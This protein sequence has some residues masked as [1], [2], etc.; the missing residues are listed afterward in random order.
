MRIA[1]AGTNNDSMYS[2]G[3][4]HALIVAYALARIGMDVT[5]ITNKRPRFVDDLDPLAPGQVKY[6]FT[7]DFRS[8]IPKENFDYVILIP[9]GIFLPEFYEAVFEFARGA[10]ARMALINFE[11]GNW[12]NAV[13][14]APRDLRLWEYW[15]RAV[16]ES[17]LV[18]SS[19]R[20]SDLYAR[21]FY[22]A[23]NPEDLRFEV[24]GPPIN[25][26]AAAGGLNKPKDGSVIAFVRS[27]DAHKG[28]ADL[29][30]LDP[31]ILAGRTLKIVAG[32]PIDSVFA[33]DL[34]ARFIPAG[35]KVEFH[36]AIS[37][38]EKFVLIGKAQ[39]LLFPSRFEGFGYPPV[40]AAYMGTEVACYDLEV[41]EETVGSVAHFAPVGDVAALG[42]AL[43]EA[44]EREPRQETLHAAV[45]SI[46]DIDEVAL[47]LSDILLR[48][49]NAIRATPD[50]RGHACWGPFVLSD[51]DANI[52]SVPAMPALLRSFRKTGENAY[53]LSVLMCAPTRHVTGT[54]EGKVMEAVPVCIKE[55]D[56][57]FGEVIFE[58]SAHLPDWT[59]KDKELTITLRDAHGAVVLQEQIRL[60]QSAQSL[61]ATLS[62]TDLEEEPGQTKL[63]LKASKN[64]DRIS[65]SH[66]QITWV[67]ADVV[68]G[69]VEFI[70]PQTNLHMS[71]PVFYLFADDQIIDVFSGVPPFPGLHAHIPV[72]DHG[73][74]IIEI[75]DLTNE[76]WNCG[77]LRRPG[78]KSAGVVA[79]IT[80][81]QSRRPH[82]GDTIRLASGRIVR[83]E[84]IDYK[85]KVANL[86]FGVEIDPDNEGYPNA[87][88][89]V[90]R[91]TGVSPVHVSA[92]NWSKGFWSGDGTSGS[93]V[94]LLPYEA[95]DAFDPSLPVSL[96]V[97]G[98][99]EIE[100]ERFVDN[101]YGYVAR[102]S[103]PLNVFG[104]EMPEFDL[105]PSTSHV[106]LD[107]PAD[108]SADGWP[109]KPHWS[110]GDKSGRI[111]NLSP[112]ARV[113]RNDALIFQDGSVRG[114]QDIAFDK[115]A[116]YILLDLAPAADH[117]RPARLASFREKS[118]L[119]HGQSVYPSPV[120]NPGANKVLRMSDNF[121]KSRIALPQVPAKDRPRVL[122]ASIVPPDPANQGNRIVT[123]NFITHLISQGF[124]V[125]LL[126][127]GHVLPERMFHQFGDRVRVFP[128]PF[129]NWT[130]EPS[131]RL[132]R[133]V[134]EELRQ[135]NRSPA[136]S[137]IFD[138]LLE[139]ASH[140]HP[141]YI[142]PDSVVRTARAL[143]RSNE[144]HSI[145]CNY[146]HMIRIACELAPIRPLPP[147]TI[148]THDALSRLPLKFD[149]KPFD[150]M[151][152]RCTPDM[153][154]D[155]LNAVPG[156]T[157][158]AIST[159][160]Q[161][162]FKEIGVTNP[163]E[164][165]EYD[166]LKE[167]ALY[168]V[169]PTAFD[170]RRLI[171]HA[172]NNPMNQ[173]A[174]D[175]FLNNCWSK[176]QRVV[177][178]AKLVI[179]GAI[180]Q[181]VDASIPGIE[182][183]G[184]VER[185]TLMGL[186][187]TSSVAINPTL[188]GTGLKI[189]TVEAICAGLPS[190]CLP[191]AIE[192]LEAVADDFCILA[193]DAPSFVDACVRL[194]TE[195]DTW[196]GLNQSSMALAQKRFSE[197]AIYGAVDARMGWD[198]GTDERFAAARS[199]YSFSEA[200]SLDD[201]VNS[202][203]ETDRSNITTARHLQSI[204][205]VKWA[206]H[207]LNRAS[208]QLECNGPF[209]LWLKSA[210]TANL[211]T[212]PSIALNSTARCLA[213][214]PTEGAAYAE[215]IKAALAQNEMELAENIWQ[216]MALTMPGSPASA[217][218]AED[219]GLLRGTSISAGWKPSPL[220]IPL[221]SKR[222]LNT[223][224][225][226]GDKVGPGWSSVEQLGAWTCSRYARLDLTFPATNAPLKLV[227]T[228][229]QHQKGQDSGDRIIR[230]SIDGADVGV[231][232]IPFNSP[233]H[234]LE[235]EVPAQG[236]EART[237]LTISL[238]IRNPSPL[239]LETGELKDPRAMGYSLRAILLEEKSE[240][241]KKRAGKS[242]RSANSGA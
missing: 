52:N 145:V 202:V 78:N 233:R 211:V 135:M 139:D 3:R 37:D 43:A 102:L 68:E 34:K 70:V 239:R 218:F 180:S 121:R 25:S 222:E 99:K 81:H 100:I 54:I 83:I 55:I 230:F 153:E 127:V 177:S 103:E 114:I 210:Q 57:R 33:E 138:R 236:A 98:S 30:E 51:A 66:D 185:E 152:R 142:V 107:Q 27:S 199:E 143:Y 197:A 56:R 92:E 204:G 110:M 160:E 198:K 23:V 24:C 42:D 168:K 183:H 61:N 195:K 178:H 229:H 87:L 9:T 225:S 196:N 18:I 188:V 119:W 11:S 208:E 129:P 47:R 40:E 111:I 146:T 82:A 113:V 181:H 5:F 165:C 67:H 164:L 130:A 213:E 64:V 74:G 162:Y 86:H 235:F 184:P 215:A 128:L 77:V 115:A 167:C 144:Y 232:T 122:F 29:L 161:A 136:E 109:D 137:E 39:A 62:L 212:P 89:R 48:S 59:D 96:V 97:D 69:D 157:I 46:V 206:S 226:K 65:F 71:D 171:F 240:R 151:Y 95:I 186:L 50:T 91:A 126:L 7:P 80:P 38:A 1:I 21:E 228:G 154:R 141:F 13:S 44:L 163:I 73:Q 173:V 227:L 172:S 179:C 150:T 12:F 190:V 220:S 140:Y 166:G 187:G 14:P 84:S 8:S 231:V 49:M 112:G 192:G 194:L 159:S 35:A 134:T 124:D 116:V 90:D 224:L 123:R 131:T 118:D 31:E 149:G 72:H 79:C 63:T 223:L 105:I 93:R 158:L 193:E 120:E 176:V 53:L 32:G 85:G 209:G 94:V 132:R 238:E 125:D 10:R 133:H 214:R 189:K 217:Q 88:V 169:F 19:L 201:L 26:L 148:V 117:A 75:A 221:N 216:H 170:K 241:K 104:S 22:D 191:A 155:V 174:I 205:K 2:G 45:R 17:G 108:E 41:L 20:T 203:S 60:K 15:R 207:I 76:H 101:G 156:A 237:S 106:G 147:V 4:Y 182:R 234:S 6:V 242:R 200:P 175:W 16:A 219:M 58:V 28:G 36:T